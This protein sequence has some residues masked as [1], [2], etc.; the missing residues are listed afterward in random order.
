MQARI[1]SLLP[2]TTYDGAPEHHLHVHPFFSQH[3]SA[4]AGG[5]ASNDDPAFKS[6]L[7]NTPATNYTKTKLAGDI[8]PMH[9]QRQSVAVGPSDQLENGSENGLYEGSHARD[10]FEDEFL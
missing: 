10:E 8:I 3:A 5:L 9:R 4:F 1:N 6:M 2:P 7:I